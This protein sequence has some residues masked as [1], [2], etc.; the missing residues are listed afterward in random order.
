[1]V[2]VIDDP[3]GTRTVHESNSPS[4]SMQMNGVL[5]QVQG[6]ETDSLTDVVHA[7]HAEF[8]WLREQQRK[9]VFADFR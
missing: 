2:L 8:K 9:E 5:V 1:M 6:R 3:D 7:A 4:I